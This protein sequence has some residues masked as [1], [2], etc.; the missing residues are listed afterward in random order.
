M[1]GWE[2]DASRGYTFASP[3][4]SLKIGAQGAIV[5]RGTV[6]YLYY[7]FPDVSG[8][9]DVTSPGISGGVAYRVRSLRLT[10]TFGSALALRRI[11]R[12]PAVGVSSRTTE[13]GIAFQGDAF[14][15]ATP[16]NSF[17]AILSYDQ[18]N[19][20]VWA[21]T[22]ARRQV[23]NSQF[24]GP[25]SLGIGA[26]ITAQGNADGQA[27]QAGV[28]LGLDLPRARSSLQLRGGYGRLQYPAAP[29]E[30]RPYLGVGLYAAFR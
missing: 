24:T 28:L 6:S 4:T 18:T 15:Q 10:A 2:G 23:T 16:L 1:A 25:T 27:Y 8:N 11:L 30:S 20:Y 17:S 21:R 3:A 13:S 22:G 29:S 19:H 9:T 5:L 7:R 12:T 26:E 14:F